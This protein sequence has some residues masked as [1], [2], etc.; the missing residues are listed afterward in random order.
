M[1]ASAWILF[2]N[3]SLGWL[4]RRLFNFKRTA[5]PQES[6]GIIYKVGGT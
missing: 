2:V 1:P 6:R 5:W 3:Y 4:R